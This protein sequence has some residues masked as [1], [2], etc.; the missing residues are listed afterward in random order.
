M[1]YLILLLLALSFVA[2][3][4]SSD[5]VD[6]NSAPL[7]ELDRLSGVGPAY[8]QRITDARPFSGVDELAPKVKGIGP[9]TLEKIKNQGLACVEGEE[10][11]IA[12]SDD[13][14]DEEDVPANNPESENVGIKKGTVVLGGAKETISLGGGIVASKENDDPTYISK[15]GKISDY[16]IYVFSIFLIFIIG[17][18]VWSR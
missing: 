1:R 2:A 17:I 16:L 12:S 9:A 14:K 15:N 5:Q 11:T 8:A 6:I 18:L 10:V 13:E 3:D 4:C 7:D